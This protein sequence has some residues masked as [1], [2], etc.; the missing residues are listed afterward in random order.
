MR[1]FGPW[2]YLH[3]S[4]DP[5]HASL[6]QVAVAQ[7]QQWP[8]YSNEERDYESFIVAHVPEAERSEALRLLGRLFE[9]WRNEQKN[10]HEKG[11]LL[12]WAFARIGT[13][14]LIGFGVLIA[15]GIIWAL[16]VS[17]FLAELAIAEK[18]R[19]LITFLVAIS[20]ISVALLTAIAIFYVPSAELESRYSKAKDLLAILVGILGTILGFYFGSLINDTNG[21]N[22]DPDPPAVITE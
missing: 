20:T 10:G 17:S 18:A 21:A 1:D 11:G 22:P 15:G 14:A 5:A 8:Y 6:K 16:S 19:G 9:I 12:S 2:F 3:A 7:A 4:S 13:L